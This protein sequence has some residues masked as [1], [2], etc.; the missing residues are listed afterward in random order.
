MKKITKF[1]FL[2]KPPQQPPIEK[3]EIH[4][5]PHKN[6]MSKNYRNVDVTIR[7]S[8]G[9]GRGSGGNNSNGCLVILLV[10]A[11]FWFITGGWG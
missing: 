5:E 8:H 2:F 7:N 9:G 4:S 11:F 1:T 10:L 6:T 3:T